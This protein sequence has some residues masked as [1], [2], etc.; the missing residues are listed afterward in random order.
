M[1]SSWASSPRLFHILTYIVLIYPVVNKDE[2]NKNPLLNG[3]NC[4]CK[5]TLG[6]SF[7]YTNFTFQY[8]NLLYFDFLTHAYLGENI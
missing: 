2:L 8:T 7:I 6:N 4:F 3:K 1:A 5:Y